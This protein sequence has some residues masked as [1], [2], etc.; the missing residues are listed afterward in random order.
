MTLDDEL[1]A[2]AEQEARLCTPPLDGD[3]LWRLGSRVVALATRPVTVEIVVGE[4]LRFHYAMPG[5]TS[6][7][8][9]WVQRKARLARH[10]DR[11]SLSVGLQLQREGKSL[12]ERFGLDPAAF[13]PYGGAVPLRIAGLGCVGSLAVSGLPQRDD[14]ALAAAAL[15]ECQGLH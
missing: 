11:A 1:A 15:A 7:H 13:A 8:A 9:L 2:L 14:H 10:F 4:Q 6:S 12:S 3:A 5:T